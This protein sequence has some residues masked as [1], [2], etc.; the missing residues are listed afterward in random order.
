MKGNAWKYIVSGIVL[1]VAAGIVVLFL[2]LKTVPYEVTETYYETEMSQEPY[3][4][5][6]QYEIKTPHSTTIFQMEDEYCAPHFLFLFNEDSDG[7]IRWSNGISKFPRVKT[8]KPESEGRNHR[9]SVAASLASLSV[10][11]YASGQPVVIGLMRAREPAASS[12]RVN[13]SKRA[14]SN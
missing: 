4:A 7:T 2:P 9:I 14:S 3:T 13:E 10:P 1:I 11:D 12:Y 8:F 6:E 5:T